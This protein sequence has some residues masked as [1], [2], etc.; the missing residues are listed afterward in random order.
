MQIKQI[1]KDPVIDLAL[2]TINQNKQALVFVNAKRSAEKSAEIISEQ[3]KT[4]DSKQLQISNKLL[5]ALSSPTKQCKRLAKIT[6]KGIAFHHS[7]LVQKQRNLIEEEFRNGNIKI[8]CSTPTLAAGVDLPAFRTIIRDLKRYSHRGMIWIPVL[9]YHQQAGRAG[10]PSFDKFGEAITI[11]KK[12][13]QKQTIYNN[14][15]MGKPEQ[16][17]SKLAV[18][19]VLRT[20]LLALISSDMVNTEKS[21]LDFFSK[22][23]WAHQ[24]QDMEKLGKIIRR[25]LGQLEKWEFIHTQ[26]QDFV[27]ADNLD[28]S[29]ISAT[30]LGKRVAQ[31]YLDP[32]T[33]HDL[34]IGLRNSS[35]QASNFSF[36]QLISQTLELRPLLTVRKKD[37]DW[38]HDFF[39]ANQEK[40][41]GKVPQPYDSAYS[42]FIKSIKT[43]QMFLAWINE[44]SE[45]KLLEKFSIR[46]GELRYKVNIA[47]WLLYSAQELSRI[48]KIMPLISRLAKLRL[49]LKYGAK[50]ELLALLKLRNIGRVRARKL[51]RKNIQDIGDVKK[52]SLSA[53]QNIVGKKTGIKIK[54]QVGQKQE[55][56]ADINQF[57]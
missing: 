52:A 32:L 50:Q 44:T 42:S 28:D 36:F 46:P 6:K 54:E 7:G 40:I 31:L 9:E 5:N 45:D 12:P 56:T 24:F 53:I 49:Q 15:I 17:F 18:E 47:D 1:A 38:V 37:W 55:K 39:L 14:Y 43:S 16:I 35:Q 22:T 11:A 26:N 25:T 51:F 20:Y 10:R 8:I 34:V 33:A 13:R 57:V 19:P 27:S 48:L 23:F 4:S 30:L 29:M 21:I 3:I 41:L 2:D